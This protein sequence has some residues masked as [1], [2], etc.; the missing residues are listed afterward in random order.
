MLYGRSSARRIRTRGSISVDLSPRYEDAGREDGAGLRDSSDPKNNRVMFQGDEVAAVAA[1]TEEH[2]I[3]AARAIKVEYEVL[4][5]VTIVEQALDGT[6]PE[7]FTGGNV[8]EAGLQRRAISTPASQRQR[9]WS[10]RPTRP[11][12]SPTSAWNRTARYANGTGDKLTA[13]VS[14]QGDQ[15][16]A[17]ELRQRA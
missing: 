15:R 5:H 2:A 16:R 9:T 3:D 14:T 17:R 7:V 8:R 12:S 6:A 11:T 13:W 1:D 10:R 4:P